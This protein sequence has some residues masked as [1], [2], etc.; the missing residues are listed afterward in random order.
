MYNYKQLLS[1]QEVTP[2]TIQWLQT[3]TSPGSGFVSCHA[4]LVKDS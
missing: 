3:Y 2:P 4:I 1:I